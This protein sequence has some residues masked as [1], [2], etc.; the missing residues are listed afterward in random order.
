MYRLLSASKDTYITNRVI[1]NSR[2]IDSNTGQAGTLDLFK[3]YGETTLTSETGSLV[4]ELSRIL[5]KFDYGQISLSDIANPT[6][7][8]SLVL[9]DVYGGQTT[10]SNFTIAL[11]PLSRAFDEGR[12]SDVVSYRDLDT[13]NFLKASTTVSWVVTGANSFGNLGDTVDT[14]VSGD[15]GFGLQS[16]GVFKTF[17]RGD[18]DGVFDIT[19]LVS[20]SVAG[21][22][23]NHGF[24]LSFIQS[25]E[26]DDKTRFVKRFGSRH[27]FNKALQPKLNIEVVDRIRDTGGDPQ[28]G[29]SQS[30]FLY[31]QVRG[32]W[33]NLNSGSNQIVGNDCLMLKLESSK[34]ISYTT[35]S[36]QAN[37]SASINHLTTSVVYF[38]QS[39]TGSQYN[40]MTGIYDANFM[41]DFVD[42][43]GLSS[44]VG[45]NNEI[46]MKAS[47][48]SL[49]RTVTYSTNYFLFK[50]LLGSYENS[51]EKN[52]V[53][54]AVNLKESY[55]HADK[56]RVRVVAQN[57]DN[58]QIATRYPSRMTST[59]I[60]DMRW[61]LTKAYSNDVVIPFSTSTIMSTDTQGMYFDLFMQDL[62][63][64]EVY[65]LEFLIKND[66]GKD[67]VVQNKG[68]TFKV[69][70]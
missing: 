43:A 26:T 12:G 51:N 69:V 37:F 46:S 63:V 50:R 29:V 23:T 2:S 58:M 3:L 65:E 10:P 41:L 31:N 17:D 15:I 59:I 27:T 6:F 21:M 39:F 25:E 22:I 5:I 19:T 45:S 33:V 36:Y 66:L 20:A 42:T 44:F 54:N 47:W 68:F 13:A 55:T 1:A 35:S 52:Y 40:N 18:E 64:N 62:D 11:Y 70:P 67:I 14:I 61:R 49:D 38:S 60:P 9:K 24:R 53:V 16:L 8:A 56:T 4:T 30:F 7:T 32:N 28:F 48:I 34:S 57:L